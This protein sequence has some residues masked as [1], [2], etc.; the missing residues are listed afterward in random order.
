MA[1]VEVQLFVLD[2]R[3]DVHTYRRRYI[4]DARAADS[5]PAMC[6][7]DCSVASHPTSVVS[8]L[9]TS[10][11]PT[12]PYSHPHCTTTPLSVRLV[13]DAPSVVATRPSGTAR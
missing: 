3:V 8:T 10:P 4:H 9:Q 1:Y 6:P 7:A 11:D 2:D 13:H 12:L 5:H